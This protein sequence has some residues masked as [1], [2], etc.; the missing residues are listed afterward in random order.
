[1]GTQSGGYAGPS[2][3]D[4]VMAI[5]ELE[6]WLVGTRTDV[7]AAL[8]ILREAGNRRFTG[9]EHRMGGADTG[10]VRRYLRIARTGSAAS[11]PARRES[12]PVAGQDV[13]DLDTAR[14]KRSA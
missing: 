6:I 7:D 3:R 9:R 11:R 14:D 8:A 1:M 4:P 2:P 10:R 12:V 13:I 5:Q